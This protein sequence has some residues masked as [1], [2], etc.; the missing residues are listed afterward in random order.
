VRDLLDAFI[1]EAG[2]LLEEADTALLRLADDPGDGEAVAAVLRAAHTLKGSAGV[3]ALDPVVRLVHGV[4]DLLCALRDHRCPAPAG[5]AVDEAIAAFGHVRAWLAALGTDRALPPGAAD[6]AEAGAAHLRGLA[7]PARATAAAGTPPA[8]ATALRDA[9]AA[10]DPAW[11]T[12]P[13]E[14]C[15]VRYTPPADAFARGEDPVVR[16]RAIPGIVALTVDH[17]GGRTPPDAGVCALRFGV[18]AAVSAGHAREAFRGVPGDVEVVELAP[19]ATDPLAPAGAV[20]RVLTAQ[21]HA[22]DAIGPGAAEPGRVE[23]VIAVT[24]AALAAD[25]DAGTRA[26]LDA[27]ATRARAGDHAALRGLLARLTG[28]PPDPGPA[29]PR[30]PGEPA[31]DADAAA[32]EAPWTAAAGG[33]PRHASRTL[34]VDQGR[35]DHLLE[36][37]GELSVAANALPFLAASAGGG[38]ADASALARSLKDHHAVLDRVVGE[39]RDAVLALR[40]VPVSAALG[41]LPA[42]VHT[43]GRRLGRPT[44]LVVEGDDTTLDKDVVDALADPLVH[45]VRNAVDH[46][47]EDPPERASA[48]KPAEATVRIS[49]ARTAGG[50]EIEVRDDG[51]GIDVDAVRA[52]ALGGG[53]VDGG[54]LAAMDP[55]ETLGLVMLPGVSTARRVSDVSGRGVGMDAVRAAV[56]GVGGS[57]AI[58]ST[59]GVGT[60]VRLR[61]P[62]TLRATGVL[63]VSAGGQRFGL[64]LDHVREV[65]RVPASA[66]RSAAGG[67]TAVLRGRP[68][69][70]LDLAERLG[71]GVPPPAGDRTVVVTSP[72][73]T[74]VGFTVDALH[75]DLEVMV[76]PPEGVLTASPAVGGT[77]LLGDGGVLI[78]LDLPELVGRAPVR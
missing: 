78:V 66:L 52:A 5:R 14:L 67:T 34:R 28:T 62:S 44:R 65:V 71:L 19:R 35:V 12:G 11:G 16:L 22:L 51:R 8:W 13:P 37:V 72:L 77:A 36:L 70:L 29:A 6:R 45:L 26:D 18:A 55:R 47:V 23:S 69:P 38:A 76:R 40:T 63:V 56:A 7:D 32:P 64:P 3:A 53:F 33:P 41:G 20:R 1:E 10:R 25:A 73:G 68:V 15:A 49:A 42:L 48:D 30:P 4:E 27:A 31:P 24:R 57:V 46:G 39:V 17:T 74:P 58:D 61:L 2:D 75:D 59:P 54:R 21:L 50:V 9:A 60:S 43:L